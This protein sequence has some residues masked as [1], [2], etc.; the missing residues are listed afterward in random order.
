MKGILF[1]VL[2]LCALGVIASYHG[3]KQAVAEEQHLKFNHCLQTSPASDT[4]RCHCAT[5]ANL[6]ELCDSIPNH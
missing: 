6:P 2:A 3:Y 5:V 4:V 1:L